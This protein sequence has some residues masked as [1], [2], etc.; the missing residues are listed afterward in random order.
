M[1]ASI[2]ARPTQVRGPD[3]SCVSFG[4]RGRP[5]KWTR[6]YGSACALFPCEDCSKGG[7]P[8]GGLSA[9]MRRTTSDQIASEHRRHLADPLSPRRSDPLPPVA[10]SLAAAA[11]AAARRAST[12]PAL[13]LPRCVTSSGLSFKTI[14]SSAAATLTPSPA[15][16]ARWINSRWRSVFA[17]WISR[18]ITPSSETKRT[19]SGLR[20][21]SPR[22]WARPTTRR[23]QEHARAG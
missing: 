11:G 5:Q 8:R 19:K 23:R 7:P 21:A 3:M 17:V 14:R 15:T 10:S 4:G 18:V 20:A 22:T 1:P 13:A 9:R 16:T 6:H 12:A 2:A